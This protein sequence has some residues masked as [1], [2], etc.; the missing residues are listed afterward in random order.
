M[1]TNFVSNQWLSAYYKVLARTWEH[2][3]FKEKLLSAPAKTLK[4]FCDF[5]VPEH[6]EIHFKEVYDRD[7]SSFPAFPV[8]VFDTPPSQKTVLK[9]PLVPA[10]G[11]LK[12]ELAYLN[13]FTVPDNIFCCCMCC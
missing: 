5:V 7:F 2:P 13:S 10:P 12:N 3:E 1:A 8:S 9:V 4:E 6:I 11:N